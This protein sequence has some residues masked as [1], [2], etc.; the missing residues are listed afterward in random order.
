MKPRIS[1]ILLICLVVSFSLDMFAFK[2]HPPHISVHISPRAITSKPAELIHQAQATVS[3]IA[4]EGAQITDKGGTVIATA[5]G[6]G[7]NGT[8]HLK[9]EVTSKGADLKNATDK[10]EQSLQKAAVDEGK[11]ILKQALKDANSAVTIAA[12]DANTIAERTGDA[13]H[14]AAT[15]LATT[16]TEVVK[17][18][19]SG[20]LT[21]GKDAAHLQL[22][23]I[24]VALLLAEAEKKDTVDNYRNAVASARE[25]ISDI[26]SGKIALA[27]Q[28]LGVT[29]TSTLTA[30]SLNTSD[31]K[32]TVKSFSDAVDMEHALFESY[33]AVRSGHY[34]GATEAM[35]RAMSSAG[36][37][38][39]ENGD[40]GDG[41]LLSQTGQTVSQQAPFA[42]EIVKDAKD[43]N[44]KQFAKDTE[45]HYLDPI[46][47][48]KLNAQAAV[49]AARDGRF[50]EATIDATT[51]AALVSSNENDD[52]A[53]KTVLAAEAALDSAKQ[54]ISSG[55]NGS[56]GEAAKNAGD[57]LSN[58]GDAL[59]QAGDKDDGQELSDL[60]NQ[61]HEYAVHGTQA[62]AAVKQVAA[63]SKN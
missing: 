49:D 19:S 36:T 20:A 29:V 43:A 33:A 18:V 4:T 59:T 35:G 51:A 37:L 54:A 12:R 60:G 45:N 40:P 34:G 21:A 13:A 52:Q 38:L 62:T 31:N 27:T 24:H 3:H 53:T 17:T 63:E 39:T 57:A 2:I 22:D 11:E 42:E 1:R 10:A 6:A 8:D 50:G 56:Y 14:S 55:K 15:T 25:T 9:D 48:A 30:A 47:T 61:I 23:A 41:T 58:A 16:G 46:K 5:A 32:Q 7:V 26:G 44:P 28:D